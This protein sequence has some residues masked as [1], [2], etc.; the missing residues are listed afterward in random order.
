VGFS[1][2]L[3][4]FVIALVVLGPQKLPKLVTQVGKWAGKARAMARQFR[5]QLESEINLEELKSTQVKTPPPPQAP[6]V[7]PEPWHSASEP[8]ATEIA[9][10]H[11]EHAEAEPSATAPLADAG[12]GSAQA[13]QEPTPTPDPPIV[14]EAFEHT[15]HAPPP[16]PET[17]SSTPIVE[18][19]ERGI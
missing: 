10:P 14:S 15:I 3:V 1:E 11:P 17:Q 12:L 6:P 2:V 4:I 8:G 16:P 9:A 19:H 13:A 5:E 18:T 7:T